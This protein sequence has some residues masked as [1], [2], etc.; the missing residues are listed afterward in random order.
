MNA[1]LGAIAHLKQY[2]NDYEKGLNDR[3][4]KQ[5]YIQQLGIPLKTGVAPVQM[6]EDKTDTKKQASTVP[7]I[8]LVQNKIESNNN[9]NAVSKKGAKGINQVMDSTNLD[10]GYGVTPARDNSPQERER[11]GRDYIDAL[12]KHYGGNVAYALIAYNWGPG[13]ADKWLQRGGKWSQLPQETQDYLSRALTE[14]RKQ[15]V[16]LGQQ[17]ASNE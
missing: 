4:L 12:T 6:P 2:G 3:Q 1:S 16:A 10:P 13:N 5:A 9:P 17:V 14:G 11:V 7:D 8:H 15:Q